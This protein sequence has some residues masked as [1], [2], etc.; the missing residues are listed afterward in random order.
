MI[1]LL[2]HPVLTIDRQVGHQVVLHRGLL[3][4]QAHVANYQLR[5]ARIDRPVA[6]AHPVL[7]AHVLRHYELRPVVRPRTVASV[8][9]RRE[10][11]KR[12]GKCLI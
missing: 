12:V 8:H 6:H 2:T 4:P 7:A 1:Q 5:I 3:A 10:E 11:G 9:C